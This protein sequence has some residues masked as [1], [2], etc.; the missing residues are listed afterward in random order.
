MESWLWCLQLLS[1]TVTVES[2]TLASNSIMSIMSITWYAA[3]GDILK[4]RTEQHSIL[5]HPVLSVADYRLQH[6]TITDTM[7]YVCD[8]VEPL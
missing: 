4:N 7:G 2:Y 3:M 1:S 6:H 5:L 8:A